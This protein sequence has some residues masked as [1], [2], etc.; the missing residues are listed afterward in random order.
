M[1]LRVCQQHQ[2]GKVIPPFHFSESF[3]SDISWFRGVGGVSIDDSAFLSKF[4]VFFFFFFWSLMKQ[5]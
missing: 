2:P 3:W 5:I 4:K 1:D